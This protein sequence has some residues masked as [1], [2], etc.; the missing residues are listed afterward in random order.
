[1]READGYRVFH[2]MITQIIEAKP[3]VMVGG[4]DFFH[5]PNPSINT[6][7]FLQNELRRLWL[8]GIDV[9]MLAGNHEVSDRIGDIASSK[10]VDDPWRNIHSYVAPYKKVEISDGIF[11]HMSSHHLFSEQA[12]TM[13]KIK[14]VKDAINIFT[15]H[16]SVI[17]P[18]LNIKLTTNQSPRE[19]VVPNFLLDDRDWSYSL[20]GH[21]H[22]RGFVG[23]KDGGK[24][25]SLNKK[26]FYNGSLIRRG[27][28]DGVSVL[29]RGWT[30]WEIDS[31]G[32]FTPTFYG[33]PQRPQ[34]DFEVIDGANLTSS[35][36]TDKILVNLKES[37]LEGPEFNSSTAPIL[38]QTLANVSPEKHGSINWK[39]ITENSTHA[40]SWNI[41]NMSP[42]EIEKSKKEL[43][44]PEG[45]NLN[46]IEAYDGWVESSKSIK[47]ASENLRKNIVKESR[48]FLEMGQEAVLYN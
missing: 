3:D 14:P 2:T 31:F 17:D 12:E 47:E 27:F 41:K 29:D 13:N 40:F 28:S 4:G 46:L 30:M 38:R 45:E 25:D 19:V 21:I 18:I 23:S 39:S 20:F 42:K 9:R 16:G 15:T 48:N 35:E 11:L 24:T 10:V 8:A 22:E 44:I 26:I 37:Q 1:M 36:I 33:L 6:I 43:I 7:I 34:L 5:N 32:Q